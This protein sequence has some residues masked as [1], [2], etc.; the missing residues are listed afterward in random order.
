MW[1]FNRWHRHKD[2]EEAIDTLSKELSTIRLEFAKV[3][4]KMAVDVRERRK[5]SAIDAEI[6]ALEAQL[7]GSA[8]AVLD[9]DGKVIVDEES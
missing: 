6:R 8:L 5:A 3:R 4:A 1:I 7:G 9:K 2:L